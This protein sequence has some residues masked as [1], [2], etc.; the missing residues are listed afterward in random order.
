[1]P[2]GIPNGFEMAEKNANTNTHIQ[3]HKHFR[4]YISRDTRHVWILHD[5]SATTGSIYMYCENTI[6]EYFHQQAPQ[7]S[8]SEVS[9][10]GMT[11]SIS[12]QWRDVFGAK[13]AREPHVFL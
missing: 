8:Y 6:K 13:R 12:I 5:V 11:M 10:R 4:I 9:G 1:M 7:Q 2:K 3:T